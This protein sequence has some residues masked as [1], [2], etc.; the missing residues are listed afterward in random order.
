MNLKGNTW[1]AGGWLSSHDDAS[2]KNKTNCLVNFQWIFF[3]RKSLILDLSDFFPGN[4]TVYSFKIVV[5][6]VGV[7]SRN[8]LAQRF[9]K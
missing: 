4:I 6:F 2:E 7:W 3:D 5:F 8:D 9:L 1:P